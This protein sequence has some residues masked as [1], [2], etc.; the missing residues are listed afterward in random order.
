[1]DTFFNVFH[2]GQVKCKGVGPW[3]MLLLCIQFQTFIINN[4]HW[5]S[6]HTDYESF[7]FL[8]RINEN[9]V[10][11][12]FMGLHV[13]KYICAATTVTLLNFQVCMFFVF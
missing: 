1:V 5:S 13:H 4:H 3:E 9:F 2:G 8:I 12:E 7:L 10:S 11:S 6:K